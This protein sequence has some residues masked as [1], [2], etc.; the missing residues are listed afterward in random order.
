MSDQR[1]TFLK[2]SVGLITWVIGI[3]LIAAKRLR[4]MSAS[5]AFSCERTKATRF[6]KSNRFGQNIV[7]CGQ[8]IVKCG[9]NTSLFYKFK[10]K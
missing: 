8:N 4:Q 9:Q 10:H 6:I 7:K 5:R 1:L 2:G 3:T